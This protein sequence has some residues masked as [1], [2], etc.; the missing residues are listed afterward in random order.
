LGWIY[1]IGA[2]TGGGLFV[3]MSLRLVANPI[4]KRALANFFASLVQLTVLLSA[5]IVDVAL[6]G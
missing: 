3:I 4:R 6:A 5:G 2:V 1:G